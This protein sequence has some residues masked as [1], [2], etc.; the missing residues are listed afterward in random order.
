ML[1]MAIHTG[2][3]L[4][5]SWFGSLRYPITGWPD[6][7]RFDESD[8]GRGVHGRTTVECRQIILSCALIILCIRRLPFHVFV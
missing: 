5:G 2:L 4:C 8:S 3:C 1:V 7:S 6:P